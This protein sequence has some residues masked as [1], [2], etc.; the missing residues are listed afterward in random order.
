MHIISLDHEN[1]FT[2][3][4]LQVGFAASRMSS[5][6][7]IYS[8]QALTAPPSSICLAEMFD[9]TIDKNRPTM[10]LNIGLQTGVLLRTV[11]DTVNGEL[12]D[13]RTRQATHDTLTATRLTI[14][15]QVPRFPACQAYPN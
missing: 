12:T 7:L 9:T 1:T 3:L 10:F 4:S 14:P 8:L 6:E 15:P 2:T 11:V 13:T 5:L